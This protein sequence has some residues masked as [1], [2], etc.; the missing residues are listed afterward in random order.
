MPYFLGDGVRLYIVYLSDSKCVFTVDVLLKQS[1]K[2]K[3]SAPLEFLAFP[4]NEKLC[5]VS[6]LKEYLCRKS[7]GRKTNCCWVTRHRTSLLAKTLWPD[8]SDKCS[9]EQVLTLHYLAH[10]V[11]VQPA[12]RQRCPVAYVPVDVVLQAAGWSSESTFTRFYRKEP[13]VNMGQ[14]LLDSYLHKN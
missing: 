12:H 8:G 1:R 11:H 13:A 14:A 10:T 9:M 4:Q 5:I 3:H 2:G 6:V 7:E